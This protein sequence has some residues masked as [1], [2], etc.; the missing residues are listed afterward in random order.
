MD[1]EIKDQICNGLYDPDILQ[2]VLGLRDQS[3]SLGHTI[4]FIASKE[5]R[6][7]CHTQL[8]GSTAVSKI[9]AIRRTEKLRTKVI[10]SLKSVKTLK[11]VH[12]AVSRGMRNK[13]RPLF[14]REDVLRT[15]RS[16]ETVTKWGTSFRLYK[17]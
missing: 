4:G 12:G 8:S 13:H 7:R 10:R 9:S 17:L 15:G 1:A 16:V 2:E 14:A 11:D 3:I 6:K 5:S